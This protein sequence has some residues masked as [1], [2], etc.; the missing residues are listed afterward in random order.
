M[1]YAYYNF[2]WDAWSQ[3]MVSQQLKLEDADQPE[4]ML[5]TLERWETEFVVYGTNPGWLP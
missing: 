1:T 2:Q 3:A 4:I 5:W